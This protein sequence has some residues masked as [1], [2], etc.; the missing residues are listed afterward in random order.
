VHALTDEGDRVLDTGAV[1]GLEAS[2]TRVSW[3]NGGDLRVAAP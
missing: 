2:R 1:S 3:R